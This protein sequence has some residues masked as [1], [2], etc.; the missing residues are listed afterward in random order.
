MEH[1]TKT[2]TKTKTF[3]NDI[4]KIRVMDGTDI[5]LSKYNCQWI[6]QIFTEIGPNLT[7]SIATSLKD[8]KQFMNVSETVLQKDAL[9]VEE[10][11]ETFNSLKSNKS[12]SHHL[13]LIFASV[14]FFIHVTIFQSFTRNRSF[15]KLNESCTSFSNF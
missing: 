3:K 6:Q 2:K 9:Q 5:F 7:F 8:F 4:P 13:L 12:P 11:K 1:N 15:P 14:V 10:L